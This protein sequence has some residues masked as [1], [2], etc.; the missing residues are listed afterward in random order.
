MRPGGNSWPGPE[1]RPVLSSKRGRGLLKATKESWALGLGT[2]LSLLPLPI[3]DSAAQVTGECLP[4][5]PPARWCIWRFTFPLSYNHLL[6]DFYRPLMTEEFLLA[7][8]E[9]AALSHRSRRAARGC[10]SWTCRPVDTGGPRVTNCYV[11][12][13]RPGHLQ[14][15]LHSADPV[16]SSA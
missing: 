13:I 14:G 6:S 9:V 1:E 2:K 10:P 16:L 11:I 12:W 4:L 15:P 8:S 7:V 3:T 5:P